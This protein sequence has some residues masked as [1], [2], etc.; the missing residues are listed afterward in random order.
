MAIEFINEVAK[1][2]YKLLQNLDLHHK[3]RCY[4]MN[5]PGS[6]MNLLATALSV[7]ICL[8]LPTTEAI[9][10]YKRITHTQGHDRSAIPMTSARYSRWSIMF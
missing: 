2:H 9:A 5:P 3:E 4:A 7:P 6:W 10:T 8:L 1:E